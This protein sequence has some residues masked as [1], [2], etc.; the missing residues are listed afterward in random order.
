DGDRMIASALG[1]ETA[2]LT[3]G[4]AYIYQNTPAGWVEE[5]VL[6][7]SPAQQYHNF[8]YSID[9][10]GTRAVVGAAGEDGGPI[11]RGAVF[12]FELQ[13]GSWVQT[14]HIISTLAEAEAH[15]G[16]Y[17]SLSGDRLAI[18]A[19]GASTTAGGFH[20]GHV[21]MHVL[22][23]GNWRSEQILEASAGTGSWDAVALDLEDDLLVSTL[24]SHSATTGS[25]RSIRIHE[26]GPSGWILSSTIAPPT[27]TAQGMSNSFGDKLALQGNTLLISAPRL[28]VGDYIRNG[29]VF[30]YQRIGSSWFQ[31][32]T[33]V[34]PLG[35]DELYFGWDID[36]DGDRAVVGSRSEGTTSNNVFFSYRGKDGRWGLE[37][38]IL[39][40]VGVNG[41][42]FG[43]SVSVSGDA[44]FAGASHDNPNGEFSGSVLAY[45]LAQAY[46]SYC[47]PTSTSTGGP[48]LLFL[49]GPAQV[50]ASGMGLIVR[51]VPDD[52]GIV[53]FGTQAVSAPF[54]N[55]TRCVGGTV[56]R[57]D[58]MLGVN[59]EM[60]IPL[61]PVAEGIPAGS[62]RHFQ[63]WFRDAAAAGSFF[64]LSDA[65]TVA[66]LP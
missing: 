10:E 4:A 46:S 45:D 48:A 47:D 64:N 43:H 16:Q 29:S 37:R 21:D 11:N 33:L 15:F 40:P 36:I 7:P 56:T 6:L 49:T 13:G 24:A 18:S 3:T 32:D 28:R 22:V 44:L 27:P 57:M 19:P 51:P 20:R 17:L 60:H 58:Y 35:A 31:R 8:G 50:N 59:N 9:L 53:Y 12:V 42:V 23:N 61:D 34:P 38:S 5:A 14:D 25:Q 66:F 52:I 63:A 2:G 41:E 54:G 1:V 30:A 26:R 65:I 62:T 55:G 39:E